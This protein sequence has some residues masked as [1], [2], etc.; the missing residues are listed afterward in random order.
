MCVRVC[1]C[2]LA[3]ID[4]KKN[5]DCRTE[6]HMKFL[7]K[8][9]HQHTVCTRIRTKIE[10]RGGALRVPNTWCFVFSFFSFSPIAFVLHN[11]ILENSR[12]RLSNFQLTNKRDGGR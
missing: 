1:E 11:I 4:E 6:I 7:K 9:T 12:A 8:E 2:L 3:G 5:Y 10:F